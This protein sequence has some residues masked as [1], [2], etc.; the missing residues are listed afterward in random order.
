MSNKFPDNF[1][2]GASSASYQVE[3]GITNDWSMAS[4]DGKVPPAGKATNH[5]NLYEK[6]FDIAKE[7]NHNAH[8]LSIEWARIE[9]EKGKYN[10]DEIGHY[11]D[12]INALKD[13]NI[14]PFVTLWHFTLPIW[15]SKAGGFEKKDSPEIFSKYA[16]F[17]VENLNDL[18]DN[19][20]TINEPIIY[21]NQGYIRGIWPPFKKFKLFKFI[22]VANNLV[23][24]HKKSYEIIKKIDNK[25][26]VGVAKHNIF[27]EGIPLMKRYWNNRF[28]KKIINHQDF[29]GL[30]HYFHNKFPRVKKKKVSDVGWE[31]YPEAIYHVIKELKEYN[32]PI[33]ITEN[34]LAD[35]KDSMRADFIHDYLKQIK[36]AI[37]EGCDVRGYLHWALTDNFEWSH[38]YK[39]RFGLVEINYETQE[40]T[41]RD[42]AKYYAEV[43]KKNS[44]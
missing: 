3:G 13:R 6:D 9:P 28:L 36:K 41:I 16:K 31:I 29:I 37:N 24:A 34:G 33:Y 23:K 22:K 14:K 39:P 32:K 42:S 43:I 35:A 7:L 12:V 5:Y 2:W 40:R 11:R 17:V 8:R 18:C 30:N 4:D 10:Q 21:A 38:G 25:N 20:I 26:K 44:L 19:W 1:L 15:F 27:F